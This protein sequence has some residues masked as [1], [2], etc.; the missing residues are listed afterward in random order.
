MAP[1]TTEQRAREAERAELKSLQAQLAFLGGGVCAAIHDGK[2]DGLA[3]MIRHIPYLAD[4]PAFKALDAQLRPTTSAKGDHAPMDVDLSESAI[5][6]PIRPFN[7][8]SPP[9]KRED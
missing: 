3:R 5:E 7:P 8:A 9:P 2:V 6:R 1:R 4:L